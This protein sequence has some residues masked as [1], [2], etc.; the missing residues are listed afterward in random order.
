MGELWC[1]IDRFRSGARNMALD[2]VLLLRAER[3][4][5]PVTWVRLYGWDPPAVSIGSHQDPESATALDACRRLGISVVNRP[6][7]GRAVF[8]EDEVTY[9]VISN[10]PELLA[11]G[12]PTAYRTVAAALQLGLG[13]VG[14]VTEQVRGERAGRGAGPVRNPCFASA[15][16]FE[17]TVDSRKIAGSAQR[18]LR[19]SFLQHGSIPLAID[20]GRMAEVLGC[21]PE[22]LRHRMISVAEAAGRRVEFNELAAALRRAFMEIFEDL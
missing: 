13:A 2:R 14:I 20:Y 7:G 22:F 21:S 15:S 3:G 10:H 8:H 6:T 1:R 18:R 12:I 17:L 16:R 11:G 19:R 5:E 9:A 4:P